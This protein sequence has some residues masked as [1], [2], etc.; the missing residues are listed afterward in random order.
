MGLEPATS[1]VTDHFQDRDVSDDGHGIA[2]FMR[3][4]R[5]GARRS[6]W[7]SQAN[8]DVCCPIAARASP[9]LSYSPSTPLAKSQIPKP[10]PR[11]TWIH[12]LFALIHEPNQGRRRDDAP[13]TATASMSGARPRLA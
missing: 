3:I 7:F 12:R 8:S 11:T 5:F 4:R 10:N 13:G 6:A 2:P 9:R 1:G